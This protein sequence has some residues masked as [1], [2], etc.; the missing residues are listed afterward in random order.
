[1]PLGTDPPA[2]PNPARG[3]TGQPLAPPVSRANW[4][5]VGGA[6]LRAVVTVG[7]LAFVASRVEMGTVAS[8]LG[9]ADPVLVALSVLVLFVSYGIGGLRWW[10]VL[11]ALDARPSLS[12]L[13]GL[14]WIGGLASQVL[15]SPLG[16][17]VRVTA[18]VRRGLPLALAATSTALERMGMVLVLAL[19]VWITNLTSA[20]GALRTAAVA[21]SELAVLGSVG[22]LLLVCLAAPVMAHIFQR[23]A[24]ARIPGVRAAPALAL[25]VRSWCLSRWSPLSL[26][27]AIAGNLNI[28]VAAMILGAALRLPLQPMDYMS[29]IPTAL[30]AMVLPVSIAGWGVRE[31]MF[32]ALLGAHA[33]P[34]PA[35]VAYSVTLGLT[36]AASSLPGLIFLWR[37]I[38]KPYATATGSVGS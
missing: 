34:A 3:E 15:P 5:P 35:A 33:I 19:L 28:V 21:V 2:D 24:L 13:V 12:D 29:V 4:R 8:L 14:F 17:A 20:G 37:P 6:V 10:C 27:L 1:M 7:A 30:L 36:L 23:P 9:A 26:I 25:A 32:V 11:R 16:D 18:A 31:G 38:R 22:A